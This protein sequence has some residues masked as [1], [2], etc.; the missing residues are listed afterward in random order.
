MSDRET[1][2][3]R[4]LT[5]CHLHV[6]GDAEDMVNKRMLGSDFVFSEI[7]DAVMSTE[8][9]RKVGRSAASRTKRI[10]PIRHATCRIR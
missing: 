3:L 9:T 10:E 8:T 2:C 6:S 5:D 4:V 7:Q 1:C